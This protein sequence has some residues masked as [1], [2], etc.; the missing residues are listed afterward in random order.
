MGIISASLTV[1][2]DTRKSAAPA[3]LGA[4]RV[5]TGARPSKPLTPIKTA[6]PK[7]ARDLSRAPKGYLK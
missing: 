4:Q 1:S 2:G 7:N 6:A 3:K 5:H